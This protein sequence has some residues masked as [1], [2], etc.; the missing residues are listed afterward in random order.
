[1][2][3]LSLE[4]RIKLFKSMSGQSMVVYTVASFLVSDLWIEVQRLRAIL[5]AHNIRE[6]GSL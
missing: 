2:T 4:E 1:M 5:T 6:D 3:E